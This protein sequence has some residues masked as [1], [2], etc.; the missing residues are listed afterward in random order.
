MRRVLL[1]FAS[2]TADQLAGNDPLVG[3]PGCITW[4]STYNA[5][6]TVEAQ[7]FLYDMGTGSEQTLMAVNLSALES[8]RDYIGLHALPFLSGLWLYT[9]STYIEGSVT[10]WVD[11][12]CETFHD[13]SDAIRDWHLAKIVSELA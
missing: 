5:N 4:H 2:F 10:C 11:H 6:P 1:D 9:S 8:T 13:A 3:G 7:Y 12:T